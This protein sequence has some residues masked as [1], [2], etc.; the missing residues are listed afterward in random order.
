M[1]NVIVTLIMVVSIYLVGGIISDLISSFI[2]IPGN[3]IGMGILYILLSLKIVTVDY[4]K[5]AGD[6]LLKH[7]SLFF[8]PFGV[9]ILL[10]FELIKDEI[11]AISVITLV[12]TAFSMWLAAKVVD[13]FVGR[14]K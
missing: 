13:K 10:Y 1:I 8:I 12:S 5:T 4:I 2:V 7:M 14:S 6:Y 11:I 3:L 9:S